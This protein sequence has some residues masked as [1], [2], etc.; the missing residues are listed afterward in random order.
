[1]I[2]KRVLSRIVGWLKTP[3]HNGWIQC[4]RGSIAGLPLL[5]SRKRVIDDVITK[6]CETIEDVLGHAVSYQ[7]GNH[8]ERLKESY[9]NRLVLVLV[10]LGLVYA[11]SHKVTPRG[12][13]MRKNSNISAFPR[14]VCIVRRS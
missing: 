3:L 4:N 13:A 8:L 7:E 9:L 12:Q 2:W 6:A 14:W 10:L 5:E 1:M 11:D